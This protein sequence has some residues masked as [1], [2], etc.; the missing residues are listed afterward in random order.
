MYLSVDLFA[1][2]LI[3]KAR[4]RPLTF[5]LF[6]PSRDRNRLIYHELLC[7]TALAV[8]QLLPLLLLPV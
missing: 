3:D 1:P 2:N 6:H 5:C 8:L 7:L 4:P